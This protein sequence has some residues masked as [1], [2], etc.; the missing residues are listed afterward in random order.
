MHNTVAAFAGF[1]H[2]QDFCPHKWEVLD[3]ESGPENSRILAEKQ[4]LM[5][6]RP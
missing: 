1:A 2:G 6:C 5:S 4:K 3:R